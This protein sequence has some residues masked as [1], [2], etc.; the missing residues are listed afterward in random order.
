MP[1]ST[2]LPAHFKRKIH[3]LER[4][5]LSTCPSTPLPPA[6]TPPPAFSPPFHLCTSLGRHVSTHRMAVC[7]KKWRAVQETRN[8]QGVKTGATPPPNCGCHCGQD[9]G[10][11]DEERTVCWASVARR[12]ACTSRWKRSTWS[13]SNYN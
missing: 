8:Y 2:H 9:T 12:Q 10:V 1:S 13:E 11:G 3:G 7:Y 6:P 5:G 4:T